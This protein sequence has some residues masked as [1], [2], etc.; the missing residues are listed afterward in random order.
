MKNR[1]AVLVTV[2]GMCAFATAAHAT[3][4]LAQSPRFGM[5]A[6]LPPSL[7][8]ASGAQSQAKPNGSSPSI[9]GLWSVTFSSDGAVFDQG[10]DQWH[11]DGTEI[12]NDN[13][14]PAPANSTGNLCVG[15]YQ[16]TGAASY[17]LKHPFWIMDANGLLAGSGVYLEQI[18]V[19]ASGNVYSGSFKFQ[20]FDLNGT[21]I[22]ETSGTLSA[23]RITAD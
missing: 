21:I 15:V 8:G 5:T 23:Q 4:G 6:V 10:F 12:L 14:A 22:F 18:T 13:V 2:F 1:I 7:L 11:S 20:E 9:V 3:C 17:K 16:K 19:A